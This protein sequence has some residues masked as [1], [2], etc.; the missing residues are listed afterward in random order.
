MEYPF[1][2]LVFEGGGVKGIA[3]IGA[4]QVL[5]KKGIL[6][7]ITRVGGASAGAINALL[8]GLGYSIEETRKILWKLDFRNFEDGSFWPVNVLRVFNRYGWYKGDFFRKWIGD[9]IAEKTGSRHTTFADISEL[10]IENG[11]RRVFMVGTNLSTRF[12]EIYSAEQTPTMRLA[13]AV[14]ISMSIPLFFK[15]VRDARKDILV[16]GGVLDNY[17]VKLFD[18]VKYLAG[19]DRTRHSFVPAYYAKANQRLQNDPANPYVYNRETLGFRLDTKEEI[20]VFRDHQQ[21]VAHRIT[22]F[23]EYAKGLIGTMLESQ[24]SQHLHSDDWQRSI[25]IDTLGVKTTDF[26]LSE[27]KKN[28]LLKSGVENTEAYFKWYEDMKNTPVNR[29]EDRRKSDLAKLRQLRKK[30]NRSK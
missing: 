2:N 21:P 7:N 30:V 26:D 11:F 14:R 3:Y 5:E 22:S 28:A 27:E 8:F 16:D 1:R 17:P 4:M 13:D 15:A 10:G 25:Y 29:V 20:E 18:R 12:A 19:I 24:E 23:A 6:K 9:L